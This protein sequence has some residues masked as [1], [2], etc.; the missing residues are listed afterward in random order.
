MPP[1]GSQPCHYLHCGLALSDWLW[2]SDLQDCKIIHLCYS[3]PLSLWCFVIWKTYIP[4]TQLKGKILQSVMFSWLAY[5]DPVMDEFILLEWSRWRGTKWLVMLEEGESSGILS[6]K[7]SKLYA[8]PEKRLSGS[9]FAVSGWQR[10]PALIGKPV[11]LVYFFF[12]FF[13]SFL[14]INAFFELKCCLW[15]LW[16]S[17]SLRSW[18]KFKWKHEA[19]DIDFHQILWGD[20]SVL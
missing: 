18:C 5:F 12:F 10:T 3:Q 19:E 15:L 13:K 4:P 20:S 16:V 11:S 17:L 6:S 9:G 1:G 7:S 8:D 2:S 14:V